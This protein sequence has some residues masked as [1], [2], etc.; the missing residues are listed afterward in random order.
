MTLHELSALAEALEREL[1]RFRALPV[2]E[3]RATGLAEEAF[4]HFE[5]TAYQLRIF[6]ASVP[7]PEHPGL[8]NPVLEQLRN[9]VPLY[10]MRIDRVIARRPRSTTN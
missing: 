1:E 5:E 9:V 7:P 4:G 10:R 8:H 6:V 2:S 3:R